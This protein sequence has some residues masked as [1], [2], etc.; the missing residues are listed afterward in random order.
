MTTINNLK[1]VI[2]HLVEMVLDEAP[3]PV[4][5]RF[6]IPLP[7]DLLTISKMF[8]ASGFEFYLVGGSV[9][10]AL[11]GKEPKDLDVTT[12]AQ[13]DQVVDILKQNP[14]Y[15]I[16]EIGKA[17]GVVKVITPE[18][19]EYEIAT[20]RKDIGKGRRPDSVEFTSIDQ[21]VARRDLTIN[22]LFYDIER[23]EIVDYVGGMEDIEKGVVRTV[24]SPEERFDEDRLR[25]LRAIRFA[26]RIGSGL[27]PAASAAIK[28]NNSLE[29]VSGER[30]RDEFLKGIKSAKSVVQFYNLI[31]EFGLWPQIFP[32]LAV[33][34]DFKET[35][36]IPV[37]L[38]V[39]LG[40][41]DPKAIM[42]KLNNLKY[43]ADEVSQVSFL[44]L[45]RNLN[46]TN[47]YK[48]KKLFKNSRLTSSDLL[49]F[50]RLVGTPQEHLVKVFNQYEPSVT[51]VELQ[52]QGYSGKE[53]GQEMERRETEIFRRMS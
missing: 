47:A 45:F 44:A 19:N 12:N 15:K 6:Q 22:A 52:A 11:M 46:V 35:K 18:E 7:G 9:R 34:R 2:D 10:D 4:R 23:Q 37:A 30:I 1:E 31:S 21:D 14:Q 33:S 26:A 49:E 48:L 3:Q 29:G 50:S 20:F 43:P 17:F 25:I 42:G 38:G 32:G 8:Q 39:L 27:D 16:L 40:N 5:K 13:P 28:A 36:N 51:G 24:G 41:N 53:L